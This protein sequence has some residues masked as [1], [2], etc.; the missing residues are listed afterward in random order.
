MCSLLQINHQ[1][2]KYQVDEVSHLCIKHQLF[3]IYLRDILAHTLYQS[4]KC[5][6][7]SDIKKYLDY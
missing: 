3:L 4:N 6:K 2:R 5:A 1:R 7:E